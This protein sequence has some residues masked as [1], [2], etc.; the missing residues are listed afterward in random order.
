MYLIG[1]MF[2]GS[3]INTE[4]QGLPLDKHGVVYW[5]TNDSYSDVFV[6]STN[7]QTLYIQEHSDNV[8]SIALDSSF[9]HIESTDYEPDE[10]NEL[11][12]NTMDLVDR[13]RN[14]SDY[15]ESGYYIYYKL[16]QSAFGSFFTVIVFPENEVL[17]ERRIGIWCLWICAGVAMVFAIINGC[18]ASAVPLIPADDSWL[19]TPLLTSEDRQVCCLKE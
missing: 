4:Y 16:E 12:L 18:L 2:R 14:E 17:R 5:M 6:T 3:R 19:T 8:S 11:I 7:E 15:V 9:G 13:S 1:G 10:V